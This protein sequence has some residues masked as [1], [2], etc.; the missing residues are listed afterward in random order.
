MNEINRLQHRYKILKRDADGRYEREKTIIDKQRKYVEKLEMEK[1]EL[2]SRLEMAKECSGN[3]QK[4]DPPN[5]D[6]ER[7]LRNHD[8]IQK[9]ISEQKEEIIH[10]NQ[11][12]NVKYNNI[13]KRNCELREEIDHL[14]NERAS[15][16][17]MH[18]KLTNH[19][20]KGRSLMKFLI[21]SAT[22]AYDQ[23]DEIQA[24]LLSLSER[25]EKE[26]SIHTAEMKR[27]HRQIDNDEKLE[28]FI[29]QKISNMSAHS[30]HDEEE[31]GSPTSDKGMNNCQEPYEEI[32]ERL[33]SLIG[34]ETLDE[35]VQHFTRTEDENFVLFDSINEMN[36]EISGTKEELQNLEEEYQKIEHH[37]QMDKDQ[38]EKIENAIKR[39][40]N[41]TENELCKKRNMLKDYFSTLE[42]H[43]HK[44]STLPKSEIFNR[45]YENY[46][47]DEHNVIQC[48]SILE[49]EAKNLG[50]S[51]KTGQEK[52][53][54][55]KD[56]NNAKMEQIPNIP[57]KLPTCDSNTKAQLYAEKKELMSGRFEHAWLI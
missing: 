19:L 53:E 31:Q 24:R 21:N 32:E 11:Q 13:Y 2:E 15:F 18:K 28:T 22:Q 43:M 47:V 9:I 27:L 33:K 57:R 52:D 3:R 37:R 49:I 40:K 6:I 5:V 23:R 50:K 51:V 16:N 14:L 4:L 8:A 7:L 54:I 34:V 39:K 38:H 29:L 42:Q 25:G 55:M 30:I 46:T 1:K 44:F 26:N 41:R 56:S 12:E 36:K 45:F 20:A 10:Q 17:K 48:L 35:V